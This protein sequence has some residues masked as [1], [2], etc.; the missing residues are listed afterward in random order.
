[1]SITVKQVSSLEKIRLSGIEN[2][3]E[4]NR[5]TVM[6]GQ[7]FSYQIAVSSSDQ[8]SISTFN[9]AW[10]SVEIESELKNS[11]E[12]YYVKN[13]V[14]DFAT[15][16]D[17]DDDY[18][19]KKPSLMPDMLLPA[20]DIKIKLSGDACA[21]WLNVKVPEN[22]P[23]GEYTIT[24][25]VKPPYPFKDEVK[26]ILYLDVIDANIGEQKTL[27]TQWFHPDCIADVHNVPIYS[28]EH[29]DLIEK[30]VALACELGINTILTP[31]ITPSLDIIEGNTRPCTQL[32]KIEKKGNKFDF[33]FTLLGKWIKLCQKCG[34]KYFEMAH[35][36]SQWGLK[37]APNIKVKEND[38]EYYMFGWH[39]AASSEAYT[40]FLKQFLPS[41]IEYLK[42][43]GVKE[44]CFFHISDEPHDTHFEAYKAAY[45]IVKPLID[46]CLIL[47]A[48]SS[49]EFYKNGL[50]DIPVT[51]SNSI[52][53]FIEN[54]VENQWVYYC[55]VQHK[56]LGNRFI[57]MP[58]YRNRIL[59]LQMYKYNVKGLLHWGYNFYNSQFSLQ[60]INPYVT[61]SSD[62]A[63][64][65]GDPF[66]VYPVAGG[67][68][69]SLRAFV[70][71]E[72][73]SDIEVCRKL[74]EFIGR[75][76]VV[77][78]IDTVA[79]MNLTFS[80]YPRN[81]KFIPDLIEQMELEIKKHLK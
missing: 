30:Y 32:V 79:D 11:I 70:F 28:D 14:M 59:G 15:Y 55:C 69:P 29:W 13:V 8:I 26:Q 47:D 52:D 33:D 22:I 7:F 45:D 5:K 1:M 41:L 75:E 56:D 77:E 9:N 37:F 10:I 19:E 23:A 50:V 46:A 31:I 40:D 54:K 42:A 39:T 64:P 61:T 6:R 60:K 71:K 20:D 35:L 21:I 36:F 80:N 12:A 72:A 43:A 73:L 63:F 58:S 48:L 27:F 16:E 51:A 65:S 17:A 49:Y 66:S 3:N 62:K 4:F 68:V 44:N 53:K 76:K 24:V 2:V 34:I 81:T 25:T 67:V 74:E 78:L 18:I 38:K 57:S